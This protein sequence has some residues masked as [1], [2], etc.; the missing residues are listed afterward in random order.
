[1]SCA[2]MDFELKQ[3]AEKLKREQEERTRKQRAKVQRENAAKE[4]ARK[5]SVPHRARPLPR[6]HASA[7]WQAWVR[8][9]LDR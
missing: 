9:Q 7:L 2:E 6:M 3:R 8:G 1:M 4:L 5:T